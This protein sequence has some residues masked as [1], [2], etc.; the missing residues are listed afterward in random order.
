[1]DTPISFNWKIAG[2]AG[3]GVMVTSEMFARACH[4]HGLYS[5]NYYEYPSLIKG[6]HQTGQVLASSESA[7]CHKRTLDVLIALNEE[8]L[9][10]HNDE[11]SPETIII[12]DAGGDTFDIEQY[13]SL[14]NHVFT[15]D[16]TNI[17][18]E[19]MGTSLAANTAA[20]GAS[21]YFLGLDKTIFEELIKQQFGAKGAE[22]AEG[23]IK[24]LAKGYEEA[25]KLGPQKF[26]VQKT[27]A[28]GIMLNGGEAIGSGAMA[29]GL[30]FYSAYP[31]SPSSNTF[32]Y[33]AAQQDKFPLVVR[34]VEDEIAA[35]NLAIGASFTGVRSMTGSAGG[36]F[37]LMVEALSL[38]GVMETPL[39]ILVAQR[40][41]P[42]TGLP[43]WTSQ[44][45]LQF[46]IRAGHG[47]FQ[48][49]VLTPGTVQEHFDLTKRAFDIA[50]KYQ[51]PVIILSDKYILESHQ[52]MPT[53]PA[54]HPLQRLSMVRNEELPT[55]DSY[56]R[57]KVTEN[58]I[59]PR[60]IPGQPHGLQ[61]TNSYEHDEFGWATEEAAMTKQQV[62]KRDR[63][64]L[65]LVKELPQ[66]YLIGPEQADVTFVCWGSTVNMLQQLIHEH[67]DGPSVNTI[68]I[69]CMW[70]FPKEK[71]A[72]LANRAS[73]LVMIEGNQTGL[74]EQLI[75][76]ETG[77]TFSH[78]IRRYD[79]RPFYVEDI[80]EWVKT[81]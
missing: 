45:D 52:T 63:K 8:G 80:V 40:P 72:E 46:V 26:V 41:G 74:G 24:V 10:L 39:V 36:G 30:Q 29:G 44:G 55:D 3:E 47:E 21:I 2:R 35:I 17:S 11:F 28:K 75:R 15:I 68:H 38:T 27:P 22:V 79:G 1:M 69:P 49:V 25:S 9:Q 34:H 6:G 54:E 71:F 76:Q 7:M 43:T 16:F 37:A 18:R 14:S 64:L 51:M 33:I 5:F 23:N 13:R 31:M 59:S 61:L 12:A 60:S 70:P 50:E 20:V 58:G 73:K 32:H 65:E 78:R 77:M 81:H 62:E 48:K 67:H 53:P 19:L 56:R 66:P 57:F 42:A 4:R